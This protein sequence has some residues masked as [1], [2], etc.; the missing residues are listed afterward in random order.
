M[1]NRE[2]IYN[3]D[4]ERIVN[5]SEHRE[6]FHDFYKNNNKRHQKKFAERAVVYSVFAIIFGLLGIYG[7]MAE[8]I[9]YSVLAVCAMYASF[10]FGRFIENGKCKG[11]K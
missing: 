10:S 11:W 1:E 8:V 7:L 6:L 5:E 2:V 4:V 9:A 3:D